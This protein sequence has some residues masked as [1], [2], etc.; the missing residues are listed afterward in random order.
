MTGEKSTFTLVELQSS[1]EKA[2]ANENHLGS[3][4]KAD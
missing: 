3:L 1:Q 2:P 4:G